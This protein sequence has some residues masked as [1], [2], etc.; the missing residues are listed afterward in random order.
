MPPRKVLFRRMRFWW[1]ILTAYSNRYKLWFLAITLIIS[2]SFLTINKLWYKIS[3]NNTVSIGYV[4]VYSLESLPTDVLS[5][6]TQSL[7][8]KDKEGNP[9]PSL[10]SY[11]TVSEDGK[12]YVVFLKDNLKWHD[13]TVV[14]AKDISIAIKAVKI[15]ALNNKTLE[16]KLP[17]PI[18][19]FPLVLDKP[20]FKTKT[21]Y[22]TGIFRIVG[23]DEKDGMVKRINLISKEKN[24]PAVEIKFY[25]TE[26]QAIDALKIGE[27]KIAQVANA[28][29]LQG[30]PN[31]D[32]KKSVDNSEIVTLFYNTSDPFLSSKDVRQ[33]LG[34]SINRSDFD[35]QAA[36]GPISP[37]SWAYNDSLKRYDYN[38]AK[39]KS[40]ISKLEVKSQRVILSVSPGLETVAQ[41]I[42]KDWEVI[43][44]ETILK[45]EKTVPQD[46]QILLAVDKLSPD[47][48]QY[49]LWH[50]TQEATNITKYKNVKI[51]KLLEDARTIKDQQKRKEYYFDF[52]RFLTEDAPATFLYHPY[53]YKI[54]YKNIDQLY[55]KL[56]M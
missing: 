51:D 41:N 29:N 47:P 37:G 22:G 30:W 38:L 8:S 4:G 35:G 1:H 12:T 27:I 9:T 5:L 43:G 14:D 40:L 10:A 31:L 11:W 28:Q 33:A 15:A 52:Q 2:L 7:I 53:R 25:Q 21:F 24:L 44:V 46:F 56:P 39:A 50:S 36:T 49:A 19:S 13:S 55:K 23:I 20:V 45:L 42:K 26:T 18:A 32:V 54:T 34:F 17:N 3:K 48:D 16:F 6:A